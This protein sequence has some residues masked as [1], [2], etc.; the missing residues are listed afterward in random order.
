MGTPLGDVTGLAGLIQRNVAQLTAEGG[1]VKLQAG[2]SVVQAARRSISGG[3]FQ[4]GQ[5]W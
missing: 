3:F 1:N 2:E 5:E 4:H